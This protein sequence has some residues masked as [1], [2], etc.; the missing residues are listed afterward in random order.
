MCSTPFWKKKIQVKVSLILWS[1]MCLYVREWLYCIWRWGVCLLNTSL[2]FPSLCVCVW[3]TWFPFCCI[4]SF[5]S[6]KEKELSFW[7]CSK[8]L[9]S[10]EFVSHVAWWFMCFLCVGSIFFPPFSTLFCLFAGACHFNSC[11]KNFF[12]I[13]IQSHKTS[14]K[15]SKSDIEAADQSYVAEQ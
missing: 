10:I 15:K 5:L 9:W 1:F 3:I 14:Q 6:L 11:W 4:F 2:V 7:F 12:S 13:N 8:V